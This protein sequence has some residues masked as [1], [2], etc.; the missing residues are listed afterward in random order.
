LRERGRDILRL[1][2]YFLDFYNRQFGKQM[3]KIERDAQRFLL[4]YSWPGNVRELRNAIERAVLLG[5]GKSIKSDHFSYLWE[6]KDSG[7]FF[8]VKEH[9]I[10]LAVSY[11]NTNLK[12][13][14]KLY[15]SH[16]LAKTN[17]NKTEA[18]KILGISRPTLDTIIK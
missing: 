2:E 12:K 14:N 8:A 1:A 4:E 18:A 13:L 10:N 11:R 9:E 5:D 7:T 17:G 16:I 3:K 15:A 6:A